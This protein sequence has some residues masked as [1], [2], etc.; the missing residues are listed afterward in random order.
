MS[1]RVGPIAAE[2][3]LREKEKVLEVFEVPQA[4]SLTDTKVSCEQGKPRCI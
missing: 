2:S 4:P 1:Y 3:N